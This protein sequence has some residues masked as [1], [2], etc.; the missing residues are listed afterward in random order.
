MPDAGLR[1]PDVGIRAR[2]RERMTRKERDPAKRGATSVDRSVAVRV[3]GTCASLFA[4]HYLQ[5]DRPPPCAA[6]GCVRA[7]GETESARRVAENTGES[8]EEEIGREDASS[9]VEWLARS[10][11][12]RWMM[13]RI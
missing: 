11:E 6:K 9:R 13:L 4:F 7:R 12:W 8:R 2:G 10:G 1:R 5:P 3:R